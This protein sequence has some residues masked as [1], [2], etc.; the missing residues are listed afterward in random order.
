MSQDLPRFVK[1]ERVR[2]KRFGTGT[3]AELSGV[4]RD[5]KVT[6]D[7][8]DEEIGLIRVKQEIKGIP[9]HGVG[10]RAAQRTARAR[11]PFSAFGSGHGGV[12][13]SGA[14][15]WQG[16]RRRGTRPVAASHLTVSKTEI[17]THGEA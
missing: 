6:V 2:H 1:G 14:A 17:S 15:L 13:D 10:R 3:I 16:A 12:F 8:D 11:R 7:F 9:R 5:T 4:G